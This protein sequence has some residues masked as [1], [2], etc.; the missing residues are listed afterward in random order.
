MTVHVGLA[1]K[2]LPGEHAVRDCRLAPLMIAAPSFATGE[3]VCEPPCEARQ[4]DEQ[5]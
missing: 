3:H 4:Q 1:Y 2:L 5:P